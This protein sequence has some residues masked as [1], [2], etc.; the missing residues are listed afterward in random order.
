MATG[1]YKE[2]LTARFLGQHELL[3]RTSHLLARHAAYLR[4]GADLDEALLHQFLHFFRSFLLDHQDLEESRLF[5][6]LNRHGVSQSPLA[7]LLEEH[8]QARRDLE[9]LARAVEG[10]IESH[11]AD[12]DRETYARLAE[13]FALALAAHDWKEN[14]ILYPLADLIDVDEELLARGDEDQDWT[15]DEEESRRWVE[16]V[17]ALALNWPA[18]AVNLP[19][20]RIAG[21]P[22]PAGPNDPGEER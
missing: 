5:P 10:M 8:M 22:A 2:R 4:T 19:H 9:G 14:H 11:G 13:E 17:E 16:D 21:G 15:M 7:K 12:S 3:Q 1:S 20:T 18:P 6:W